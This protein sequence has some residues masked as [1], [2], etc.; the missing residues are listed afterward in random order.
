M[1]S[2]TQ[3]LPIGVGLIWSLVAYA[4]CPTVPRHSVVG[5]DNQCIYDAYF[6]YNCPPLAIKNYSIQSTK[7]NFLNFHCQYIAVPIAT[8]TPK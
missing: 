7:R 5:K 2:L 1:N 4:E 3:Y 6:R 8:P